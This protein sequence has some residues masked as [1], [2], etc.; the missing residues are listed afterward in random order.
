MT[1]ENLYPGDGRWNIRLW[2]GTEEPGSYYL[3]FQD[4][5]AGGVQTGMFK[6][7][8]PNPEYAHAWLSDF[9]TVTTSL[10]NFTKGS[11]LKATG[12][13][14]VW[15]PIVIAL[16]HSAG[17]DGKY[18]ESI[19]WYGS[20]A[21]I[22][23]LD[24][25][26][27]TDSCL[28]PAL[29]SESVPELQ[30]VYGLHHVPGFAN[31]FALQHFFHL[32]GDIKE[33]WWRINGEWDQNFPIW[34]PRWTKAYLKVCHNI[35]S[36]SPADFDFDDDTN[37]P[38]DLISQCELA[39]V[40]SSLVDTVVKLYDKIDEIPGF[41]AEYIQRGPDEELTFSSLPM[42]ERRYFREREKTLLLISEEFK[43]P[44]Y[45]DEYRAFMTGR[46]PMRISTMVSL[47]AICADRES[48]D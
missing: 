1:T 25:L 40:D 21:P 12:E 31:V 44:P 28:E 2:L 39:E 27:E 38:L 29:I 5:S 6:M 4:P 20:Q 8:F 33:S 15:H 11:F 16:Y 48:I 22:A 3:E 36:E 7:R 13:S 9:A 41:V 34:E 10:D 30:E 19:W 32:N 45:L 37:D 46:K 23:D 18:Y 47:L 43:S 26:A 17:P 24:P 42:N 35:D 14:S